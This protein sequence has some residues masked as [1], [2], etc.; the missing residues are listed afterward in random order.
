MCPIFVFSSDGGA[1]FP[2]EQ[3]LNYFLLVHSPAILSDGKYPYKW[4]RQ[5]CCF[6]VNVVVN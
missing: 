3:L 1:F 6:V 5:Y 2:G 4:T